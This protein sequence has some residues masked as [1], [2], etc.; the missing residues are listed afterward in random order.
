MQIVN[1]H[2]FKDSLLTLVAKVRG[3]HFNLQHLSGHSSFSIKDTPLSLN[4]SFVSVA[5]IVMFKVT[6]LM[7]M[8]TVCFTRVFE[9]YSRII[10]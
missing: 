9:I 7:S 5:K 10:R 2:T 1:F 8:L 6:S 3:F 4:L